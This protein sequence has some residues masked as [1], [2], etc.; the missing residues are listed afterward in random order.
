MGDIL[1]PSTTEE[2]AGEPEFLIQVGGTP[3]SA[4][5]PQM[6]VDDFIK[7]SKEEFKRIAQ[8]IEAAGSAFVARVSQLAAKP[9][10]CSIEF[11][12]NA[13][14]EAGVPFVTK[15]T[16]GANFKVTVTWKT[17]A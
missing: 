3:N 10:E 14:G 9:A 12:I 4:V 5:I 1:P 11:G 16:I 17:G 15:G 6:S 7:G 13:G 8:V 2:T